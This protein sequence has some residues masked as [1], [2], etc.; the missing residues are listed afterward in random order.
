MTEK[1]K[2]GLIFVFLKNQK[3]LLLNRPPIIFPGWI[4]PGKVEFLKVF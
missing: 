2:T 3:F 4:P 1:S